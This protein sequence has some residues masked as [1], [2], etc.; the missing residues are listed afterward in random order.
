MESKIT[1]LTSTNDE[2]PFWCSDNPV[3]QN[4]IF[5][6]GDSGL[7]NQG[8]DIYFP[9]S[10]NL[11]ISFNCRSKFYEVSDKV[12]LLNSKEY[13]V[14][15]NLLNFSAKNKASK[16]NVLYYNSLQVV[17]SSR[18][19]YSN[20]NSFEMAKMFLSDYPKYRTSKSKSPFNIERD[21]SQKEYPEFPTGLIL[22]CIGTKSNHTL[23]V[24]DFNFDEMIFSDKDKN[25]IEAIMAEKEITKIKFIREGD[26]YWEVQDISVEIIDRLSAKFKIKF[27]NPEIEKIVMGR[28]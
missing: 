5:E 24:V 11:I 8:T 20:Q 15:L 7:K 2:N 27:N 9:I 22:F 13:E 28:K 4:N 23:E 19:I 26:F 12:N 10:K 3:V 16:E 14:W 21:K 25:G 6:L 17:N 18:F 1:T